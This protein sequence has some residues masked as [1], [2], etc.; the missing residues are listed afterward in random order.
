MVEKEVSPVLPR[1]H[2]LTPSQQT[3]RKTTEPL[4]GVSNRVVHFYNEGHG[5]KGQ[6][7]LY[8]CALISGSIR[9]LTWPLTD[10]SLVIQ[11]NGLET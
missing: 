8:P 9:L 10:A 7:V 4:V 2:F 11:L 5:W 3:H 6:L 1:G